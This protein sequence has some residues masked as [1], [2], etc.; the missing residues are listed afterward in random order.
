MMFGNS[1]MFLSAN[2]PHG[3][4]SCR[5]ARWRQSLYLHIRQLRYQ[6]FNLLAL[7]PMIFLRYVLLRAA[8]NDVQSGKGEVARCGARRP[9]KAILS[10]NKEPLAAQSRIPASAVLPHP[11]PSTKGHASKACLRED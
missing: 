5:I 9:V 10:K 8:A 4:E 11:R 1:N 3:K 2:L 7:T 6:I